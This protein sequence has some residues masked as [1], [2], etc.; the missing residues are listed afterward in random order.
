MSLHRISPA[1]RLP[2]L[3][4]LLGACALL[5]VAACGDG[6]SG[7]A[8]GGAL[9]DGGASQG[10]D[11]GVASDGGAGRSDD[12]G[13]TSSGKDAAVGVDSGRT[14]L[15]AHSGVCGTVTAELSDPKPSL[16]DDEVV[17]M[18]GE[19]YDK[20]HLSP[21][22]QIMY[23]TPNAGGSSV[24]S[25]VMSLEVLHY[26][27]G[28]RLLGTE[29]QVHYQPPGDAGGNAITDYLVEI[30]G[31]KVG[32]SVTR[33]YKPAPMTLSDADVSAL[34]TK[35]LLGITESSA[36]V[37]PQDKWVKQVLHVWASTKDDQDAVTRVWPT[38]DPSLKADTIVLVTQSVGGGF[39]YCH[40]LPPLGNECP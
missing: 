30:A 23:D 2:R 7:G 17:F 27:D 33:L 8:S 25:E 13:N 12:A 21:D 26:C 4:W 32:V 20:A 35:K 38:I 40:P 36:R 34:I 19:T 24:E 31:K 6:A 28:A 18:T 37:L 9:D 14:I 5:V 22:G 10:A 3:P 1:V 11:S 16:L 29:T 39:I 15:G